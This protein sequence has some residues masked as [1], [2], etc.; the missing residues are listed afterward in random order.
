M[1]TWNS[2]N[3]EELTGRADRSL[4]F[5][6]GAWGDEVWWQCVYVYEGLAGEVPE[7]REE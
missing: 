4:P 5:R 7:G 2:L 1:A 3:R 6:L